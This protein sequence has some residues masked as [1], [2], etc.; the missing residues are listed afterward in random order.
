M[1]TVTAGHYETYQITVPSNAENAQVS[2]SFT[3]SGGSGND[4]AVSIM[5]Y[6][7]YVNWQNGHSATAYYT[8]GQETTGTITAS[9]PSGA[10]YY[11]GIRQS[12]STFSD[13]NVNTQVNV[14]YTTSTPVALYYCL[15]SSMLI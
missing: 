6:S 4:I 8:S 15:S 2:G 3:A 5:D 10:T 9:L 7:D 14:A 1:I 12:F 11:S 13:K